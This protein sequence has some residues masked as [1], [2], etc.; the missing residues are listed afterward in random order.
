MAAPAGNQFWKQRSVHGRIKLFE[1]PEVMLEAAYE[2]FEW[3]EKNPFPEQIVSAG[4]K[5]TIKKMRPFTLEGLC[6]YMCCNTG[7]FHDFLQNCSKDFSDVITHIK[8]II[9]NQK[10]SGAASGFLNANLISFDL[11]VRKDKDIN[12]NTSPVDNDKLDRIAELINAN[13]KK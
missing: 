4:K 9:Y 3:C 13:A 10:Y 12:V 7:Y 11:G 8:E 2:Y 6:S 5:V 1:T